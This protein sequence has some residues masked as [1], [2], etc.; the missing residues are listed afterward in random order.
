MRAEGA[1][2][3]TDPPSAAR[4]HAP[5]ALPVRRAPSETSALVLCTGYRAGPWAVRSLKAAGYRTIGAHQE[6][7]LT[8]GRSPAC[9]RPLRY[10]SPAGDPEGFVDAVARIC[11]R[12][13]IDVVLP[14]SEDTARVLAELRPDLGS[15]A[16]VG[17]DAAAYAALCDKGRLAETAALAGVDH[18]ATVIVGRDGP[19]GPWP[20]LPGVVKPRISGEDLGGLPAVVAVATAAER[21]DAVGAF[22]SKGVEVIVQ[23]ELR[24]QRWVGQSVRDA[25]GRLELVASRIDRDYPRAAGV[26]SVMR[27]V[28]EP[29]LELAAGIGRLLD[30]ADYR[31]PSTISLIATGDRWAVH[32]VNLRLGSSVGLVI[33]S[34]LDMP[35]R[36]VEVALGSDPAPPVRCRPTTYVR[37]DGELSASIDALRGRSAGDSAPRALGH[38]AKAALRRDGMLDPFPLDP[39]WLGGTAARVARD[40]ARCCARRLVRPGTR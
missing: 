24:G 12:E 32:D 35:R 37:V 7:R 30:V 19:S 27:T 9:L 18:P 20:A 5:R 8:G 11:R 3:T 40:R 25:H 34:G 28:P 14:A 13:G 1:V 21:D 4:A 31:G 22:L 29:P 38:L 36:A 15:T 26:A 2:T 39:L 10:P 33:R 16:L 6:G 23:E 17:P